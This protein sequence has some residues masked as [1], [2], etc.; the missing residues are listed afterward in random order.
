MRNVDK[1]DNLV[2][3]FKALLKEERFCSLGDI[4]EAIINEGF[5]KINQS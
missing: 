1:K 2:R 3:A 4:V 5:D